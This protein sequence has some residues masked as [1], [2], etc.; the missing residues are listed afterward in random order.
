MDSR[1]LVLSALVPMMVTMQY[2]KFRKYFSESGFLDKVKS[3]GG[4]L[5]RKGVW[6]GFTLF[7]TLKDED[8]P[9]WVRTVILGTLGYFIFPMDALPDF[10]PVLGFTD[11]LG[12]MATAISTLMP[13]IKSDHKRMATEKVASLFGEDSPNDVDSAEA[14]VVC[15]DV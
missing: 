1:I 15:L 4:Q 3:A 6:S 12:A 8:T 5:S 7:Y 10:I 9:A 13:Y 2:E 14:E 11:D